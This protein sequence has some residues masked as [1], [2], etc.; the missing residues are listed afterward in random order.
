MWMWVAVGLGSFLVL[1]LLIALA[2]ARVLGT[3]GLEVSRLYE[4]E[5]WATRPASRESEPPATPITNGL[6]MPSSAAAPNGRDTARAS[7]QPVVPLTHP[8]RARDPA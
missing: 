6:Q 3:I 1:S 5:V 7:S 8:L 4:D 2:F